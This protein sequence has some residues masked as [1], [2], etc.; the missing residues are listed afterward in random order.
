MNISQCATWPITPNCDKVL[1]TTIYSFFIIAN[2]FVVF[3]PNRRN[4]YNRMEE[5][6]TT[7]SHSRSQ[8]ISFSIIL[9]IC[10]IFIV[11]CQSIFY[12]AFTFYFHGYNLL[13]L[14]YCSSKLLFWIFSLCSLSK[15]RMLGHVPIS[16]ALAFSIAFFI[17]L[18]PLTAWDIFFDI[19]A[20]KK[21]DLVFYIIE[22]VLVFL[23]FAFSMISPLL[24]RGESSTD[25]S[26]ASAW[27]N[28]SKK[29]VM[30]APY[31]WPTKSIYLQLKVVICLFLLVAG[32]LINVALPVFSKWIVDELTTPDSFNYWLI[33]IATVLKFLQGNGAMGGFLN[34]VR[35]YL[36][37]PIQQY[38]TRE[39]EVQ[40]FTHLHSLSLRWHLSRKT[41]HVL[42]VM[43]RGTS[44]VN[45]I[46]NYILF[47]IVPTIADI[48]IAVIFFFSTFSW[49]FGIIVL[50][51]MVL[52]LVF[53]IM[54]TEWR[55]KF[56]RESNEKDNISSA[57]ATDSL[58]N[59]ETVKYYGNEEY[60]VKR[61]RDSI[62]AFQLLE[63]KSQASLAFLNFLQNS[64]IGVGMMIGSLLVV[65][66]VVHE[67]TMT[68][69]DYVLFTT[70]LLQLYT[71]LNFFGTIYRVIQKAFVDMENMFDLM[72]EDVEVIDIP[73]AIQYNPSDGRI[74]V[75]NLS[76]EYNSG[77]PVLNDI[78]FEI[79]KGQTVALVSNMTREYVHLN[80]RQPQNMRHLCT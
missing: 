12:F 25:P 53:T 22:L 71:P 36:W 66:M 50:V 27:N 80:T 34:T 63:W 16:L 67:K 19:N 13:L 23:V 61:F 52:Y 31:V 55:T 3:W 10:A 70:Y 76:F 59:Y 42:R 46:L 15:Y 41:G 2:I 17:D 78:S 26:N 68:V 18:I 74:A 33:I 45:S 57:I 14:I 73:N 30:V 39:L 62:E 75:N 47:N 69:G 35:S 48:T 44:S 79:G 4:A 29:I 9:S 58:L 40:L 60:E 11:I 77:I 54:I 64:I 24:K 7:S 6:E 72:D 8:N 20:R 56:L 49:Q 21:G 51:T 37:I 43:D 32:R 1:S 28:M 38:T 65:Y 5:P